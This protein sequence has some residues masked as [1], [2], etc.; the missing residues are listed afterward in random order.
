MGGQSPPEGPDSPSKENRANAQPT[1]GRR[2]ALQALGVAATAGLLGSVYVLAR[3]GETTTGVSDDFEWEI[4]DDGLPDAYDVHGMDAHDGTLYLTVRGSGTDGLFKLDGDNWVHIADRPVAYGIDDV[5]VAD[6][7]VFVVSHWHLFEL[8]DG[9]WECLSCR[10]EDDEWVKGIAYGDGQLIARGGDDTDPE[11]YRFDVSDGEWENLEFPFDDLDGKPHVSLLVDDDGRIWYQ[12]N[13]SGIF[14][15]EGGFWSTAHEDSGALGLGAD[16]TVYLAKERAPTTQIAQFYEYQGD[17]EWSLR[18]E[19]SGYGPSCVPGDS[20]AR[21]IC[22]SGRFGALAIENHRLWTL[23]PLDADIDVENTAL[24]IRETVVVDGTVYAVQDFDDYH[25]DT[26]ID[27]RILR[28]ELNLDDRPFYTTNIELEAGTYLDDEA[29][30]PQSVH[31]GADG[32]ILVA[33]NDEDETV[34]SLM[35]VSADA[36]A[37]EGTHEFDEPVHAVDYDRT[38]N[39]AVV[40]GDEHVFVVDLDDPETIAHR[41]PIDGAA[42]AVSVDARGRYAVAEN[43]TYTVYDRDGETLT[44]ESVERSYLTDIELDDDDDTIYQVGFDN[45]S[46]PGGNPVQVA[47]ATAYSFDGEFRWQRFGF[48]GGNLE[49]N[50]ADTRL[51][52][53]EYVD[54]EL[55]VLG[56]SAGSK[57][58]FRYDGER[59]A[60]DEIVERVDHYNNLWDTASAHIAYHARLDAESGDVESAQLTM[61]RQD[62]GESNTFSVSDVSAADGRVFVAGSTCASMAARDAQSVNG[63]PVGE[64]RGCDPALLVTTDDISQRLSWSSFNREEAPGEVV[65]VDADADRTVVL[66]RID[67]GE[68]FITDGAIV[69]RNEAGEAAYL[70]VV[71]NEATYETGIDTT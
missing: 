14:V 59:Y 10:R 20:G 29:I 47:Y 28:Y 6:G 11:F 13:Y 71:D 22:I 18:H 31:L 21:A 35:Y 44:T 9:E 48:D 34:G 26:D 46:L 40:G 27:Q 60:G 30:D 62:D 8:V 12:S 58:I 66:A 54:G 23:P 7:R 55:F 1:V 2:S 32:R 63:E 42:D 45:K 68:S 52:G 24:R 36:T 65:S 64:Y 67:G 41:D 33:T 57:T 16:G 37:I 53:I 43:N 19:S 38:A 51:Y 56:E 15:Y 49:D 17:G 3:N 70:A 61:A 5:V 4:V 25:T 39:R 69:D 50:I